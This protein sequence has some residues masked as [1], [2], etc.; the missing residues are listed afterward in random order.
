MPELNHRSDLFIED[1]P[2]RPPARQIERHANKPDRPLPL[3]QKSW[4]LGR[5]LTENKEIESVERAK[6]I[7]RDYVQDLVKSLVWRSAVQGGRIDIPHGRCAEDEVTRRLLDEV[8]ELSILRPLSTVLLL[9]SGMTAIDFFKLCNG[10]LSHVFERRLEEYPIGGVAE[11]WMGEQVVD[12]A[13]WTAG[14]EEDDTA[15]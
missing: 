14:D 1:A 2:G 4:Q 7:S 5:I 6:R 3:V 11:P 8:L 13:F 12:G 9:E 15:R 10:V